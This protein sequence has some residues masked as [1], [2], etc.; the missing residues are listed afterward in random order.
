VVVLAEENILLHNQ[1][2]EHGGTGRFRRRRW[3]WML[4]NRLQEVQRLVNLLN[5]Q[6]QVL[7]DLEMQEVVAEYQLQ[8]FKVIHLK[9]QVAAEEEQ[10]L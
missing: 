2:L 5:Q 1:D 7:M 9:E 8:L 6:I 10:E 4:Y 3:F